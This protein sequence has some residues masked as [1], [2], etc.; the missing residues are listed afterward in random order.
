MAAAKIFISHKNQDADAD[1][2]LPVVSD[3]LRAANFDVLVDRQ[4]LQPGDR[5]RDEIY[6]WMGLCHGAVILLSAAAR[7]DSVWVPRET[8]ILLW[9]K[10]LDPP[11]RLIPVYLD[12]LTENDFKA[13]NFKDLSLG[14]LQAP[15]AGPPATVAAALVARF[16]G[17][18]SHDPTP[19]EEVAEQIISL[20]RGI[21][22]AI[23]ARAANSLAVDLGPWDPLQHPLKA[24][25]V[26]LLQ[27]NLRRAVGALK[28]LVPHLEHAENGARLLSL[29]EPSW[30]DLCAARWVADRARRPGPKS[31]LVLN[32]TKSR[33]AELYVRR[34]S[35]KPPKL[36]WPIIPTTGI[37]GDKPGAEA[38]VEI[39]K[40]LTRAF[41][42]EADPFATDPEAE[43]QSRLL[44][45]LANRDA[46]R[47]PVFVVL[48]SGR[49][50]AETLVEL[51]T[52]L[53]LVTFFVLTGDALPDAQHF[54]PA[55]VC[56]I[57][58]KLAAGGEGTAQGDID[59]ARS[60]IRPTED[61]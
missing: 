53:P 19:L 39:E 7:D 50:T 44:A 15:P 31:G 11:F 35:C 27:V 45:L 36:S 23:L 47:E 41:R 32:A 48:Q 1:R 43:E 26:R 57:E 18:G 52:L 38:A 17:L 14:E 42:L 29:L 49:V 24:L 21:D 3:A 12:G 6:T 60:V 28:I 4:R 56:F 5:W 10:T 58:P 22:T 54:H 2:V 51:Q 34:A 30:V 40:A 16:A 37:Y 61:D 20:L 9:R 13:G 55:A 33:T 8:S 46:E 59:Y 25:A